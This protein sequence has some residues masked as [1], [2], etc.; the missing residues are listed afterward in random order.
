MPE[1]VDDSLADAVL[2][3][4]F[5]SFVGSALPR[6]PLYSALSAVLAADA[7]LRRIL[8]HAPPNQRL[9]VLL[10]AAVHDV[11]LGHID[12]ELAAWYPNLTPAHR[13][14]SDPALATAFERFVTSYRSEIIECVATR[15]TQT[16][17][18][19]RSALFVPA[20]GLLA[21]EVGPLGHLDIGSSGGLNLLLDRFR[22]RYTTVDGI[23]ETV[24]NDSTVVIDVETTGD[25][26]VP[27]RLPTITARLG[28]DAAPIDVTD[29]E[30]A[31]WLE[32][33][34]WP[35]QPERFRR[36]RAAIEIARR[37]PAELV[38]GDAVAELAG[39]IDRVGDGQHPVVTNSWVLNYLTSEARIAYLAELDRIGSERD[40]S[41]VYAEA[42][43][44][45]P[46]LPNDPDPKGADRTVLS[47]A[48]WRNGERT[49]EHLATCHPHGF[50]IH[51]R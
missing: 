48:R 4:D 19:G 32:A 7:G 20:F 27:A 44:L 8:L 30:A 40:L 28:V 16:N 6:A 15:S 37:H 11:L 38:T 35:D 26:P 43:E 29:D 18:V 49:V 39:G 5:E 31:R 47:M 25:V 34:V 2:R 33:C 10:L 36:L 13:P 51:W 9:P 22:Y 1:S 42:P 45:I 21:D 46:E 3:R 23:T 12:D 41:W 17:E 14:A 50:W 24:G